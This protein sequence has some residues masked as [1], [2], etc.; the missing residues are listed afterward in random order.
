MRKSL[1]HHQPDPAAVV[2]ALR[3]SLEVLTPPKQIAI[4][5]ALPDEPPVTSL[6]ETLAQHHWL[7]PRVDGEHLH[8]HRVWDP[9]SQLQPG[10]FQIREPLAS[11]PTVTV[12]DIDIYV[13]PGLAF[14]QKGGRLGRGKGFYDRV[15]AGARE[16]AL[17]IG[18]GYSCQ[19]VEDVHCEAHDAR[20]DAI[21]CRG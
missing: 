8:F 18:V 17:K 21:L 20:M 11:Q 16:N 1:Q 13:C 4:Y 5:C 2:A 19:M 15:L 12:Q 9:E 10:A 7:F 14:D 3:E 6:I